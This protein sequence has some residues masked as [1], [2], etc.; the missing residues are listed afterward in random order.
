MMAGEQRFLNKDHSLQAHQQRFYVATNRNIFVGQLHSRYPF[1]RT[2]KGL[3]LQV[4][5]LQDF[6]LDHSVVP[7]QMKGLVKRGET[8]SKTF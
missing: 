3:R 4:Y 5:R 2:G 6:Y 8:E 1:R 7:V